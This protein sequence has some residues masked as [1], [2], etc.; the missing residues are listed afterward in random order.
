V[1]PCRPLLRLRNLQSFAQ[2]APGEFWITRCDRGDERLPCGSAADHGS[3]G[4]S[5]EV[6]ECNILLRCIGLFLEL[7]RRLFEL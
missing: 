1:P 5:D 6:I 7:F 3:D 4:C 2:I